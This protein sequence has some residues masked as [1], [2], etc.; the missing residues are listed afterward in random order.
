MGIHIDCRKAI[1]RT[2]RTV[3]K[4]TPGPWHRITDD[5]LIVAAGETFIADA[6]PSDAVSLPYPPI[7]EAEANATLIA[8]APDLLAACVE[9]LGR[10]ED[11]ANDVADGN[12]G[13]VA[14]SLADAGVVLRAAIAKAGV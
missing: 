2:G 1:D 9:A 13:G 10:C 12:T 6:D 8:A 4:H 7:T 3:S 5:S 14:D 11:A